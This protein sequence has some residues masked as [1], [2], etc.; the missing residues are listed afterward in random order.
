MGARWEMERRSDGEGGLV[1]LAGMVA[2][3]R[4]EAR[5]VR[6]L[7]IIVCVTNNITAI[8]KFTSCDRFCGVK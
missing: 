7:G 5:K 1:R 6:L 8:L 2:C 4:E 3:G